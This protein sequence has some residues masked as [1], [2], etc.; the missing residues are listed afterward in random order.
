[1]PSAKEISDRLA[2]AVAAADRAEAVIQQ[3]GADLPVATHA[4]LETAV[5]RAHAEVAQ[6][7]AGYEQLRLRKKELDRG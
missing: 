7:M 2:L 1:M 6:A 3:R 4:A 5:A